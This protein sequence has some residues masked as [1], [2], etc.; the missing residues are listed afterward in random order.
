[1]ALVTHFFVG[2]IFSFF[3]SLTPSMLNM[4]ALKMSIERGKKAA[5]WFSTGVSLVVLLQ[6]YIAVLLTKYILENPMILEWLEKGAVVIF[7]GLS[8]YFYGQSKKQKKKVKKEEVRGNNSFQV[9]VFLSLLNMF[10]VPFYCGVVT[11]L[12]AVGWMQFDISNTLFFVTGS[13]LGTLCI[14]VVYIKYSKMI[15][16]KSGRFTKDINL[17]LSFLTGIVAVFTLLKFFI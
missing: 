1:M 13:A 4:S 3:G 14:L 15:Q 10:A 16:Q 7:I 9:G 11:T 12:D 5:I 6:A 17:V 8:I 2:F